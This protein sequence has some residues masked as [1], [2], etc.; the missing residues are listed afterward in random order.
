[1]SKSYDK[2]NSNNNRS[3]NRNNNRKSNING[4]NNIYSDDSKPRIKAMTATGTATVIEKATTATAATK[5]VA[6]RY[7]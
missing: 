1:L 6:S 3:N 4:R 7:L 5:T 2:R